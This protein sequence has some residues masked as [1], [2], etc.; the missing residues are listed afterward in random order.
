MKNLIALT[1]ALALC[2]A[3]F[4]V[5]AQQQQPTQQPTPT[6]EELEQKAEREKNAYRLLDQVIDEAQSLRLVENRVQ[7]QIN[8]GDMLWDKNQGRARS[9]FA[10]AADGI[11]E[12]GRTQQQQTAAIRRNEGDPNRRAFQ[13]R[14][15][16]VLTAAKHDAQLAYQLLASTKPAVPLAQNPNAGPRQQVDP[17]QNLEQMLIGR[18]AALDPKLAAQNAEQLMEK[19][20]F[21]RSMTEVINQ[22]WQQD[23]EAGARFADKTV[24]RLQATNILTNNEAS[25]LAQSMLVAGIRPPADSKATPITYPGS[26]APVLE[27]SAYVDLLSSVIDAA[28]KATA[29]TTTNTPR[30]AAP[31]AAGPQRGRLGPAGQQPTV[32]NRPTGPTEAQTEQM[33]ARR[34]LAGLSI[35]MPTIEQF[36]P[37][38]ATALRQKFTEMGVGVGNMVAGMGQPVTAQQQAPT[39]DALMQA[40]AN[41]PP[42][43]QTR[44]YQQAAFRALE[45]GNADRAR[46]IATDHLPDNSRD[47]VIQRI[48]FREMS[49]KAEGARFE[50]LRQSVNRLQTDG[51]KIELLLQLANDAKKTNQKLALQLLDEAKGIVSRRATSYDQFNQQLRVARAFSGLDAS[52]TFE[53][54]DPGITQLNELV[55]AASVLNGFEVSMFRDGEMTLQGGNALMNM[56]TRFGTE[57]AF[58]ARNDFERADTLAGRFQ[59]TETRIMARIMII[60][61]LLAA[62]RTTTGPP[63]VPRAEGAAVVRP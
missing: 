13:M 56:V 6:A 39:A 23:P 14:Q 48:E 9:L 43:M 47:L 42:Q 34:L 45:E 18:I 51:E 61:G 33:N 19:G 26:R 4:P 57:L 53:I 60:Q 31:A 16:L 30:P 62:T 29:T 21:F 55:S 58:L 10:M 17:E 35:A 8:A 38:K 44:L 15:E 32:V 1:L 41:A 54:L 27:Q 24:K 5:L 20:Q 12:I 36:L 52:R 28:L 63:N 37:T 2:C 3:A 7:V 25:T 11:A 22:L 50:D 59:L 40:A 49:K 46:Q